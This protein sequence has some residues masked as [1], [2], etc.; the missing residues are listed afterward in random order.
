M[1]QR[2]S[3]STLM[4]SVGDSLLIGRNLDDYIPV[5]GLIF[6]NPRGVTKENISWQDLKIAR[7]KSRPRVQWV[8]RY[9]SVTYNPFGKEFPDGGMNEAGLYVGEMTLL[10]TVYPAGKG[11]PQ[12]YHHQ[13]MQYLLDSCAT[14]EQALGTLAQ[15]VIDGHCQWHFFVADETGQ[16][17]AIEFLQGKAVI[18]TGDSMPIKVM[19]NSR[20]A[21]E[22]ERL[23]TY[24]GFGGEKPV[25]FA[26]K[27]GPERFPQAATMLRQYEAEPTQKPEDFVFSVLDQ[28]DCGNN[29]WQIVCD[30]RRRRI[31]FRTHLARNVRHVD[32]TSFDF[33][34]D[35]PAMMLD[36]HQNDAGDVS[37]QFEPFREAI[38]QKYIAQ[39]WDGID[40]GFPFNFLFKPVLVRRMS[41]YPLTFHRATVN[42]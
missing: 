31:Y 24:A 34:P 12:M 5:P 10:G 35:A 20:Y 33:S 16:A 25:D 9:G 22:L 37:G 6:V 23:K 1:T 15:V 7:F 17:A 18:H 28:L 42:S 14:V 3:C 19:C 26:D 29:K 27:T 2:H 36:I 11:L 8:S 13:W 30:I 41:T 32:L 38:N 40:M 4:V 39:M 21:D